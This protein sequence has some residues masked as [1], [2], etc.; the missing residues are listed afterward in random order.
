MVLFDGMSFKG[1]SDFEEKRRC[2]FEV[3]VRNKVVFGFEI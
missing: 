3:V 2:D 1:V